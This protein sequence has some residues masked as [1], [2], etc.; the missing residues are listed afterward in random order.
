[1][2]G[3][4]ST[5]QIESCLDGELLATEDAEVE[6]HL[7]SCS[8]CRATRDQFRDLRAA[9]RAAIPSRA[10]P[11]SLRRWIEDAAAPRPRA[12]PRIGSNIYLLAAAALVAIVVGTW[13][14]AARRAEGATI[15]DQLLA[16]HVRSLMASHLTD[17]ATSDQHTVK[18]WF[19]GKLDYSPPVNDFAGKGYPLVGGRLDYVAGHAVAA[20]V[21]MRRRHVINVLLWP[22]DRGT[23]GPD[24]LVTRQGYHLQHWWTAHYSYWVVSDLGIAELREFSAL[25]QAADAMQEEVR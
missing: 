7:A 17:V 11:D 10:A 4:L 18:P 5:G 12:R 9:L 3:H 8:E 14:L 6:T 16:T 25:L 1:M 19:N 24:G 23:A 15:V 21:Y 22:A 20:L 2:T 13:Q